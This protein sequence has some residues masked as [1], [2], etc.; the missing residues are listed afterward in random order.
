MRP[1]FGEQH[2]VW[3]YRAGLL[4]T[5]VIDVAGQWSCRT[6]QYVMPEMHFVDCSSVGQLQWHSIDLEHILLPA[7]LHVSLHSVSRI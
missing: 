6:V 4:K 5:V 1:V 7:T 2:G 3:C